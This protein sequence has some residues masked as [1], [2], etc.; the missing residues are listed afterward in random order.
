MTPTNY[1]DYFGVKNISVQPM[2]KIGVG[3]CG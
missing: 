2:L 3:N 1:D